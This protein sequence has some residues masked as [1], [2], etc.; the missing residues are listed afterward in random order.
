[1]DLQ[2]L[3]LKKRKLLRVNNFPYSE[4]RGPLSLPAGEDGQDHNQ[5]RAAHNQRRDDE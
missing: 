2:D 4:T 3:N 1:M 5:A